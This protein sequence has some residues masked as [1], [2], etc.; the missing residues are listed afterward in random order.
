[1]VDIMIKKSNLVL[2]LISLVLTQA[3]SK[4]SPQLETEL[5]EEEVENL[6]HTTHTTHSGHSSFGTYAGSEAEVLRNSFL[7]RKTRVGGGAGDYLDNV[8]LNG[9]TINITAVPSE[10]YTGYVLT[11]IDDIREARLAGILYHDPTGAR[12]L[13]HATTG[14]LTDARFIG[15][16]VSQ[17]DIDRISGRIN[18]MIGMHPH[19]LPVTPEEQTFYDNYIELHFILV[20]GA[21]AALG[22]LK[23]IVGLTSKY[24]TNRAIPS[25]QQ[26]YIYALQARIDARIRAADAS[27]PLRLINGRNIRYYTNPQHLNAYKIIANGTRVRDPLRNGGAGADLF[28]YQDAWAVGGGG[29]GLIRTP[30]TANPADHDHAGPAALA[31]FYLRIY[32]NEYDQQNYESML[33]AIRVNDET[34]FMDHLYNLAT[35]FPARL[36]HTRRAFVDTFLTL[37]V[38]KNF[39]S[40]GIR[41]Q[42][43]HYDLRCGQRH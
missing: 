12:D 38:T 31:A 39:L 20:A 23:S 7:V 22:D 16:F 24:F 1:M 4:K 21:R 43:F 5:L 26:A 6:L 15:N 18:N 42:S 30:D 8:I 14:V 11:D 33:N 2:L 28:I 37:F 27:E 25:D 13:I 9:N 19:P 40:E 3:C 41:Q 29:M 36:G 17:Y 32:D 34:A 35:C 10:D